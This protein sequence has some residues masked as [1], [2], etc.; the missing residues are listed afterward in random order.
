MEDTTMSNCAT[1]IDGAPMLLV[2]ILSARDCR[3]CPS[4]PR[5]CEKA[6]FSSERPGK[7]EEHLVKSCC[8]NAVAWGKVGQWASKRSWIVCIWCAGAVSI[9]NL[10]KASPKG[11]LRGL[12]VSRGGSPY[13][14]LTRM[15]TRSLRGFLAPMSEIWDLLLSTL[16]STCFM[17]CVWIMAH[18][19]RMCWCHG[20]VPSAATSP[21]SYCSPFALSA[22]LFPVTGTW[23][24]KFI[25]TTHHVSHK[26]VKTRMPRCKSIP[27]IIHIY[28]DRFLLLSCLLW[29][30]WLYTHMMF[31]YIYT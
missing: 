24:L 9:A 19:L 25:K 30:V 4:L 12:R 17:S 16:W 1:L 29:V 6:W 23:T 18:F 11:A 13:A 21:C 26:R 10:G 20:S 22:S 8:S 3:R 2:R 15:L 14:I 28:I 5:S 7:K 31:I 27:Y